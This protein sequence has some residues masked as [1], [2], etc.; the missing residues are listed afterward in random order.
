MMD[1]E[2]D[3]ASY[4]DSMSGVWSL[5][6]QDDQDAAVVTSDTKGKRFAVK[7][8]DWDSISATDLLSLFRSLCI[9]KG[10]MSIEKVEIYQSKFGKEA[11]ERDILYGPPKDMFKKKEGKKLSRKENKRESR[12]EYRSDDEFALDENDDGENM[13]QLRKYEVQKMDYFYA[14]VH[15]NSSKTASKIIE[16]NQDLELELTNIRLGLY[17]VEDSLEFPYEPTSVATEIPAN[18]HFD[19][20][21]ISRALNHSTV[22][23]SWDQT[24]PKRTA[25]LQ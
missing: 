8:L 14:I 19:A 25:K 1:Q 2:Y 9:S 6:S 3:S 13:A 23:L 10:S 20:S 7:H 22:K 15:C 16:E 17:I 21:K 12:K 18:Y 5:Q 24:D 11:M 4:S